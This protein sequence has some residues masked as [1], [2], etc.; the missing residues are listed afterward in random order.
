VAYARTA[1]RVES[2]RLGCRAVRQRIVRIIP[3]PPALML[4]V[5]NQGLLAEVPPVVLFYGSIWV[6][7]ADG[8]FAGMATFART[9]RIWESLLVGFAIV[10]ALGTSIP[11]R[12]VFVIFSVTAA[13]VFGGLIYRISAIPL[14]AIVVAIQIGL[15]HFV[16]FS[17]LRSRWNM[18]S[19]NI[20]SI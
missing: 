4:P 7:V 1:K 13:G 6:L 20:K 10:A 9:H 12:P 5:R 18:R 14:L 8:I 16:A 19:K 17:I 11:S 3:T 2:E 15:M